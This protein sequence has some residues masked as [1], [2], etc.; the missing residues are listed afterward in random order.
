VDLEIRLDQPEGLRWVNCRSFSVR[1]DGALQVVG[2]MTDITER[3][4]LERQLIE[5]AEQERRRIGQDLHDDVCQRLAAAHLKTGVLQSSLS[6]AAL[7]QAQLASDVG[8]ELAE[9]TDIARRYAKGLAPVAVGTE[10]LPQAM[11]DL[12][13][14]LTRAFNIRCT[15]F[16]EAVEGLVHAEA[17]AQIYRIAQELATNAAKHSQGT[18]IEISLT[19]DVDQLR[20]EVAHDGTSF[21]PRAESRTLG[22]GIRIVQQRVDA[23]GASL[24]FQSRPNEDGT[25]AVCEIP[26]SSPQLPAEFA[27]H[28]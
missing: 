1:K 18:W 19:A 12:A 28:E 5:V 22:M 14:F 24:S 26:Y 10:A 8:R 4:E 3:K 27:H 6:R 15:A 21:D 23:L 13:A 16:C 7:P 2:V 25:K 11:S 20:L 17:A 9:A